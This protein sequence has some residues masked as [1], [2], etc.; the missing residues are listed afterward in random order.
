[1]KK[2]ISIFLACVMCLGLSVPVCAAEQTE[3]FEMTEVEYDWGDK[4]DQE[5][6][7]CTEY[8]M[9]VETYI[10]KKTANSVYIRGN[11]MCDSTVKTIK[12]YYYL[13]KNYGD[14]W[15]TVGSNSA[16][17]S[18]ASFFGKT[19]VVSDLTSGIY[20]A[21]FTGQVTDDMGYTEAVTCYSP[22]ITID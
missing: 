15:V 17:V 14:G 5:T 2:I 11:V 9:T 12:G 20:R 7:V 4:I 1:M 6:S 8:I 10:Q 18:N 3:H 21:K 13:Q 16:T 19:M 22:T